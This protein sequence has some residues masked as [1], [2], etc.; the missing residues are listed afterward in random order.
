MGRK[1][2]AGLAMLGWLGTAVAQEATREDAA[3]QDSSR[4][5]LPD[6]MD[7]F[8]ETPV[9][10]DTPVTPEETGVGGGGEA[11]TE[12]APP[13]AEEQTPPAQEAVEDEAT[14]EQ[15]RPPEW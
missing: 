8:R 14:E 6:N 12:G 1:W 3:A 10:D 15:E 11:G 9:T 7:A 2:V 5:D 4:E 13:A